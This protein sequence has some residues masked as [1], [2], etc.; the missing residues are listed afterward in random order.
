VQVQESEQEQES[1]MDQVSER[2]VLAKWIRSKWL[3]L[4]RFQSRTH[5][6]DRSL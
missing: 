4:R 5:I 3:D 6:L 2:V 1:V